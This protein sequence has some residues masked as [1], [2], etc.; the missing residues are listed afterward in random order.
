MKLSDPISKGKFRQ[1]ACN[2]RNIYGSQQL[3]YPK[4]S[5]I[6]YGYSTYIK[7]FFSMGSHSWQFGLENFQMVKSC[8]CIANLQHAR[9][10]MSLVDSIIFTTQSDQ[11]DSIYL[12][13]MQQYLK[14]FCTCILRTVLNTHK[15]TC[16]HTI[17][18]AFM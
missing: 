8:P 1:H 15:H 6:V 16:T 7:L 14:N 18:G 17:L 11:Q 4:E 5:V 2:R 3:T 12:H 9:L 10:L 13:M